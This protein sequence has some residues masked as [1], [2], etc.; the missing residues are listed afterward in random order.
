[1]AYKTF[2]RIL[3]FALP[4][5]LNL[6]PASKVIVQAPAITSSWTEPV[7]L[8]HSGASSDPQLI[9]SSTGI[10]YA[11]WKDKID[12]YI[13]TDSYNGRSWTKP[14]P[15]NFPFG[16]KDSSP[17][18]LADNTGFIH[19]FWMNSTDTLLYSRVLAEK[20]DN[21]LSWEKTKFLAESAID[22][23]VV[24]DKLGSIHLAYV[25]KLSTPVT[26]SGIY[27]I[28]SNN[29]GGKWGNPQMLYQS[30]YYRSLPPEETNVKLTT[31]NYGNSVY[32]VWDNRPLKRLFL[33]KSLGGGSTWT[34]PQE[35][36]GPNVG[37]GDIIPFNVNISVNGDNVL[38]IWQSGQPN[39]NCDQY[40]Q[41]STDQGDTWNTPKIIV[42]SKYGCSSNNKLFADQDGSILLMTKVEDQLVLIAWNGSQWGNPQT[43]LS[44]IIDPDTFVP[45]ILLGQQALIDE[46]QLYL[47]GYGDSSSGD[48]WFTSRPLGPIQDWFPKPSDWS[49]PGIVSTSSSDISSIS[50]VADEQNQFHAFWIQSDNNNHQKTSAIYYSRWDG[51][52]WT[53]P[54]AIYTTS[55]DEVFQ[56]D[57]A[58]DKGRL[59]VVWSERLTGQMHISWADADKA[60]IFSEWT[61]PVQL[62]ISPLT[63][64]TPKLSIDRSGVIYIVY[65]KPINE[66]RGIYIIK[67]ENAGKSWSAPLQIF[68]AKAAGWDLVGSPRM[69][70]GSNGSINVLWARESFPGDIQML[71][72]YAARSEDQG[73]TWLTSSVVEE[74]GL[75]WSQIQGSN[76]S[77]LHRFWQAFD[78]SNQLVNWHQFSKDGGISWSLPTGITDPD[79]YVGFPAITMD[80]A[81]RL[82]L[83]Q[84]VQ[85][86]TQTAGI[87]YRVWDK[88]RW[89]V[90]DELDIAQDSGFVPGSLAAAVSPSGRL[91]LVY[92]GKVKD[93]SSGV[94]NYTLNYASQSLGIQ[95]VTQTPEPLPSIEPTTTPVTAE[96]RSP[97]PTQT[98]SQTPTQEQN[99]TPYSFTGSNPA[100][101]GDKWSGLFLGSG[102]AVGIIVIFILYK[103]I[104]SRPR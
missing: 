47:V 31:S 80:N 9:I 97:S 12:G 61:T 48:I 99:I 34:E 16:I 13:V 101:T 46:A 10:F 92:L 94:Y 57:T 84:A 100:P 64:Y 85:K 68:D 22:F 49:K 36:K 35:L 11:I 103:V 72:L 23:D 19:A 26:P 4:L 3:I 89:L 79:P 83:F 62:T 102:L 76:S 18:L 56:L 39:A 66:D 55:Q 93:A 69:S 78:I 54:L 73:S 32:V 71:A 81:Q 59:L 77:T 45:I 86:S 58:V 53:Q 5:L 51:D 40:S 65:A 82:Y 21:A 104:I 28:E 17:I 52:R 30:Q 42:Q 96:T 67:S 7:N 37:D 1:M 14:T 60:Q 98:P 24:V 8:S 33:A 25:R 70:I 44:N 43:V 91:F 27:I 75:I 90:Q 63:G 29:N 20:F 74:S 87:S 2:Y 88:D 50:L 15:V 41:F 95:D 6:T 38:L